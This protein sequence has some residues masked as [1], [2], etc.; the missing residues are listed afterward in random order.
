MIH[1]RPGLMGSR[2]FDL[3]FILVHFGPYQLFASIFKFSIL[4]NFST[5]RGMKTDDIKTNSSCEFLFNHT[6]TV[7]QSHFFK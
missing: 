4:S 7:L 2:G 3:I 1:S 6:R 5:M